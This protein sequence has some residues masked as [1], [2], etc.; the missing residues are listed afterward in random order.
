MLANMCRNQIP[1]LQ[2]ASSK[3]PVITEFK[4]AETPSTILVLMWARCP[5]FT[6]IDRECDGETAAVNKQRRIPVVLGV[7]APETNQ[8]GR[9]DAKS[10]AESERS[11]STVKL[12]VGIQ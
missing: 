2:L 10:L 6:S 1:R 8:T 4:Y 3:R 7:T 9:S 5:V 11:R 12:E